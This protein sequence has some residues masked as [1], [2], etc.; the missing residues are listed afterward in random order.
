MQTF[1]DDDGGVIE[2]VEDLR[3]SPPVVP[4]DF[5]IALVVALFLGQVE[6]RLVGLLQFSCNLRTR[7]SMVK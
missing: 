7:S 2:D 4:R 6:V 3:E 1:D 5:V